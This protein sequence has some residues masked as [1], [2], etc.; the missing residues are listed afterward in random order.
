MTTATI[1]TA[2]AEKGGAMADPSAAVDDL[3]RRRPS[4]DYE[5]VNEDGLKKKESLAAR[6]YQTQSSAA[7]DFDDDDDAATTDLSRT[8][9]K[10]TIRKPWYRRLNP[11]RRGRKPSVPAERTV[12]PEYRAS[13]LSKL[14]FHWME[15]MMRVSRRPPLLNLMRMHEDEPWRL[16]CVSS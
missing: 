9:T 2:A 5:D 1:S 11:L 6:R 4:G 12:S 15:P 13:W 14:T 10:S 7:T 16:D 8:T 3:A